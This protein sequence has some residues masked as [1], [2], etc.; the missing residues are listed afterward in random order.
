MPPIL[1]ASKEE[2]IFV[3]Q[4]V[5]HH[6]ASDQLLG[7]NTGGGVAKPKDLVLDA[8]CQMIPEE[9]SSI[10]QC[11]ILWVILLTS[12]QYTALLSQVSQNRSKDGWRIVSGVQ[13][14]CFQLTV[15]PGYMLFT[16]ITV[17]Y[18]DNSTT[19]TDNTALLRIRA[20]TEGNSEG[21]GWFLIQQL[22]DKVFAGDWTLMD[23]RTKFITEC[24]L[25]TRYEDAG[26]NLE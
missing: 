15:L 19:A 9:V 12:I 14:L 26:L 4:I 20:I 5:Q 6:H 8:Y 21:G 10:L 1:I 22:N 11:F 23:R 16:C 3:I 25:V 18:C 13:R 2:S 7:D 17:I 24:F